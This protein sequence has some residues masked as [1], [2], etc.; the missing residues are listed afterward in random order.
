MCPLVVATSLQDDPVYPNKL[1]TINL[2]SSYINSAVSNDDNKV[3]LR[4]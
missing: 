3:A 1:I 4:K 2:D